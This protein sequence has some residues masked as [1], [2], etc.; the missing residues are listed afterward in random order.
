MTIGAW[1][2]SG[3]MSGISILFHWALCLLL[4][5]YHAVWI[6]VALQFVLKSRRVVAS[7][8][9]FVSFFPTFALAMLGLV[10]LSMNFR[11]ICTCLRKRCFAR[12]CLQ[13]VDCFRHY[14]HLNNI[15]SSSSRSCDIFVFLCH[16]SLLC[17]SFSF[18]N[19]LSPMSQFYFEV[20]NSFYGISTGILTDWIIDGFLLLLSLFPSVN[21]FLYKKAKFS[22]VLIC[23]LQ[24]CGI[25]LLVPILLWSRC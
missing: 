15:N 2:Y 4:W 9:F 24:I 12:V 1:V 16:L 22:C 14:G 23:M 7:T 21:I 3:V 17:Q 13:S 5:Q 18:Q 10:W 11:N 19:C 6:S 8:L 20:F 25:H